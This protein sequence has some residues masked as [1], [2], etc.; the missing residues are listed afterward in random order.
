MKV[1]IKM[2]ITVKLLWESYKDQ[3][4]TKDA[5]VIQLQECKRAFY[6]GASGLLFLLESSF[7]GDPM[8]EPTDEEL[9]VLQRVQKE[10]EV[11]ADSMSRN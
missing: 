5:S 11:F 4:I 10:L 9:A 8:A 7:R 3:A 2:S 1:R 6:G